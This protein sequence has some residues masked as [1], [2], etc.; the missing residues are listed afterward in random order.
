M[1]FEEIIS[2]VKKETDIKTLTGLAEFIGTTQPHIS[3]K[4][5]EDDFQANW[6][7]QI[8]QKYNLSTDWIMTGAGPKRLTVNTQPV[9]Q[10]PSI[11]FEEIAQL[12]EW[13]SEITVV[14]PERRAWFKMEIL[15]T[16]PTFKEWLGIRE[17]ARK[18]RKAA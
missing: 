13:L 3:K 14:E 9:A 4:K 2:R 15:D 16:F 12:Q 17:A 10:S 18:E 11:L 7:Y 8:A 5:K 1:K 6:A